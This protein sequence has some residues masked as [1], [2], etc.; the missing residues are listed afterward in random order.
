MFAKAI[1]PLRIVIRFVADG[2]TTLL[3]G[4][5]RSKGNIVTE[6]MVRTLVDHAADL[7]ALDS[8]EQK[9]INNIFDFGNQTVQ[10]LMTLR[11]NFLAFSIDTP[12][13]EILAKVKETELTRVPIY[14]H[15]KDAVVGILHIRDLMD[16]EID[17][18]TLDAK[19]L[20]PLLRQPILVPASKLVSDLFFMLRK[21]KIS[22]ALVLDEF[23][24]I[25]GLVTMDDL[26]GSIFG[27]LSPDQDMTETSE[28]DED[29]KQLIKIKGDMPVAVFNSKMKTALP[30]ETAETM[31]GWLLH[32]FGELP[33]EGE[34][35]PFEGWEF[36]A[37]K[38]T[39]NRITKIVCHNTPT[40][41]INL[42]KPASGKN[43][44]AGK[45]GES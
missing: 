31:G 15:H 12:I 45:K 36:T 38:I 16:P 7:G 37:T 39:N 30:T 18:H 44:K 33:G 43:K 34:V 20:R 26:L 10:E 41:P 40:V 4:K 9:F 19:S 13:P 14:R 17:I 29:G 21:R 8:T 1:S 23:G 2:L 35:Y 42:T 32:H 3:I 24:G 28:V 27:S 5:E 25:I 6:D 11:S 22:F